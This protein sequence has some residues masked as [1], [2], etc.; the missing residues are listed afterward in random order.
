MHFH[1][2][3]SISLILVLVTVGFMPAQT[4]PSAEPSARKVNHS[5]F[6]KEVVVFAAPAYTGIYNE[7]VKHDTYARNLGSVQPNAGFNYFVSAGNT[8]G[9][10]FGIEYNRF[11]N[12]TSYNGYFKYP[13]TRVDKNRGVYYPLTEAAYT[14]TIR[15]STVDVPVCIRLRS[16]PA[17]VLE[18]YVEA[19][20]KANFI[21]SYDLT[22]TGIL[23][24]KGL[25]P[26]QIGGNGSYVLVENAPSLGFTSTSF[27]NHRQA[28]ETN[29]LLFSMMFG[30]GVKTYFA[31]NTFLN[32]SAFYVQGITDLDEKN[33]SDYNNVFD[34]KSLH[35]S[36]LIF[37]FGIKI[38]L[39]YRFL[40]VNTR[41]F[42]LVNLENN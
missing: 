12:Q 23:N 7:N 27:S 29:K 3:F 39:G 4:P 5:H 19:G 28:L 8:I 15:L 16:N 21:L 10:L 42:K 36:S 37:Q 35:K 34:E 1:L 25:Y 11:V 40:F 17:S 6:K 32:V 9:Y 13:E 31:S 22:Q 38:G 14:N 20:I 26:Q 18:G 33:T 2:P 41:P 30:A 24:K